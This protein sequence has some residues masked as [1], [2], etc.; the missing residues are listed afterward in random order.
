[1]TAVP[2][3]P[4]SLR[5]RR[6]SSASRGARLGRALTPIL[7]FVERFMTAAAPKAMVQTYPCENHA[8]NRHDRECPN[9]RESMSDVP[10]RGTFSASFSYSV[11]SHWY[12]TLAA[13]FVQKNARTRSRTPPQRA[14]P[15]HRYRNVSGQNAKGPAHAPGLGIPHRTPVLLGRR[16]LGQVA[17]ERLV[18]LLGDVGIELADLGR[19]GDK[20]FVRGLHVVGLHL[21]RLFQRLGAHQPLDRSRAILEGLLRVVG[22]FGRNGL[23]ALGGDAKRTQR[24]LDIV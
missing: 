1:M 9:N 5:R 24:G 19:L 3:A 6:S 7:W 18:R 14:C 11:T 2:G 17:L 22:H 12:V 23:Q 10:G 21:D 8:A 13:K 15:Q 16:N 20:A 4:G